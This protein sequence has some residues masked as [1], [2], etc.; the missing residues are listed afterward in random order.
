MKSNMHRLRSAAEGLG[1]QRRGQLGRQ[2]VGDD[3]AGRPDAGGDL[4]RDADALGPAVLDAEIAAVFDALD[5]FLDDE[6]RARIQRRAL[7]EV[8][9][10][11]APVGMRGQALPERLERAAAFVALGA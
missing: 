4:A 7:G 3:R 10:V 11:H 9:R 8:R 1:T 2:R 6:D 5:E